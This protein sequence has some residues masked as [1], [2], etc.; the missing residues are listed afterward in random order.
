MSFS[1]IMFLACSVICFIILGLRRYCVGAELGGD[2]PVRPISA[3]I[4]LLLWLIYILFVSLE[5]YELI[6]IEIGDVPTK[7]DLP[8][9]F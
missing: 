4:L 1:V 5:S 2:G 6:T 7:Y 9:N 3:A 8:D